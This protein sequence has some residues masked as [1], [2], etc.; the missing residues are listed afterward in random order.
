MGSAR[1]REAVRVVSGIPKVCNW[2]VRFQNGTHVEVSAP[3]RVL[4]K[5]NA[6]AA[7]YWAAIIRIERKGDR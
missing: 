1:G 4:A 7:G 5:L 2:T 3:S 6:R